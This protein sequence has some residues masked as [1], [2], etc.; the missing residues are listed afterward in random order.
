MNRHQPHPVAPLLED[1]GLPRTAVARFLDQMFYEAT[2]RQPAAGVVASSHLGYL[3]HVGQRLFASRAHGEPC[4]RTGGLKETADRLGHRHMVPCAM[5]LLKQLQGV[6]NRKEAVELGSPLPLGPKGGGDSKR[7]RPP[8]MVMEGE[9]RFVIDGEQRPPQ[10]RKHREL[11]VGP[12][13]R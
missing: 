12:L 13:D 7:M 4:V 10:C 11:V 6:G 3:E 5:Q 1:R 8:E 9:Q 2:K